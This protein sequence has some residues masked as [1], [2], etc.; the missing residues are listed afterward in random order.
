MKKLLTIL[1]VILLP[2]SILGQQTKQKNPLPLAKFE[3]N[4]KLPLTAKERA[5]IIEVYGEYADKYIFSKPHRLKSMK[6]L[7]RNRIV[8]KLITDEGSIKQCTKLSEVSLCDGF[9][10]DLKRD[11]T[12][13]PSTFNPLK[14]NFEFYSRASAMYHVDNTNYY[15]IIKSQYQ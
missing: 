11:E 12:F 14:Y 9:V 15:I 6:Q 1:V 4:V 13:N 7:L 10:S 8:I 5:Q 3:D 2:M